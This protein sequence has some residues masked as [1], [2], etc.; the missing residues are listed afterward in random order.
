MSIDA[1]SSKVRIS[2]NDSTLKQFLDQL[3]TNSHIKDEHGEIVSHIIDVNYE[4][5]E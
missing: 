2:H 5:I 3:C 4:V 1:G